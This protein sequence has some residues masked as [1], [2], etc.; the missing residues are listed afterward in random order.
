MTAEE[1]YKA[2]KAYAKAKRRDK[3]E[4]DANLGMTSLMDIVSIIVVYL[5]KSYASDPI[6]IQ[7]IADQKIPL[8]RADRPMQNGSPIYISS[9]DL[10]FKEKKLV[11]LNEGEI[12]QN[13]VNNHLITTLYDAMVEEA[14]KSKT[15]ATMRNEEWD[16]R[17]IIVGDANLKFSAIVDV[18]FTANR[19]G[20]SEYAFCIIQSG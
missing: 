5:L 17:A 1:L 7:P 10:V 11:K 4:D 2:K 8:S 6:V 12:D 14:D 3:G 15:I 16:A 18:M 19:A 13:E 20:Y 9:R